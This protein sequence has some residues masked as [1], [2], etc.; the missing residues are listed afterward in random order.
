MYHSNWVIAFSLGFSRGFVLGSCFDGLGLGGFL[1]F[2]LCST[3]VVSLTLTTLLF[4][5][6]K[7]LLLLQTCLWL[8]ESF[9][10]VCIL[11]TFIWRG[12]W[13]KDLLASF[14]LFLALRNFS[15]PCQRTFH[16][17]AQDTENVTWAKTPSCQFWPVKS[18]KPLLLLS[19]NDAVSSLHPKSDQSSL[20]CCSS[21][22]S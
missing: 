2:I 10:N 5:M 22:V 21:L 19:E 16:L 6:K 1:V 18:Y 4:C 11:G 3:P 20:F 17:T 13:G 8:K 9:L 14:L 7:L 12:R 15:V